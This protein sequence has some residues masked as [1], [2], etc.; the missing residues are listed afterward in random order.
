MNMDAEQ[1]ER[2]LELWKRGLLVALG[3]SITFFVTTLGGKPQN[4]LSLWF[5]MLLI[6]WL[7]I[8]PPG[9]HL[10]MSQK[11]RKVSLSKRLNTAFGYLGCAW[12][13]L[14]SANFGKFQS[15]FSMKLDASN[16]SWVCNSHL[17]GWSTF[18]FIAAL[19]LG[20]SFWYL[21]RKKDKPEEI[22]P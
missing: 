13:V 21:R 10:L 3:A 7:T 22:F 18:T 6:L 9:F 5:C 16:G 11:W 17:T 2:R 1:L 12:L 15:C 8:A 20:F 4:G 19:L 14:C